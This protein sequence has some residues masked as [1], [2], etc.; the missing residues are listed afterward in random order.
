MITHSIPWRTSGIEGVLSLLPLRL[1]HLDRKDHAVHEVRADHRAVAAAAAA[2]PPMMAMVT[3]IR[4]P[5]DQSGGMSST[6]PWIW[7]AVCQNP[8]K[9]IPM[10]AHN[11]WAL[12]R[13]KRLTLWTAC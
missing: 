6:F 10:T 3:R 4:D 7:E 11:K 2:A 13:L 12:Q 5:R 8:R 9:M 1:G